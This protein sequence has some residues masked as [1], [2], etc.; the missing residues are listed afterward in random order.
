MGLRT[1]SFTVFGDWGDFRAPG[2]TLCLVKWTQILSLTKDS[3]TAVMTKK[4]TEGQVKGRKAC[5][6]YNFLKFLQPNL[7]TCL[8][9]KLVSITSKITIVYPVKKNTAKTLIFVFDV[10]HQYI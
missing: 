5:M 2:V 3:C 6:I 1:P 7:K 9:M 4:A 8:Y 10:Y